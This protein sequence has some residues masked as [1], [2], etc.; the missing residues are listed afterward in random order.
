MPPKVTLQVTAGPI[1][2]RTYEF[3]SHDTFLFGRSPDCHAELAA[4]DTTASRHHFLLEVN[5]PQARLRDLGSL[6]GTTLNGVRHGGRGRQQSP[7][8]AARQEWPRLDLKDGDTIRVGHTV[9][10]VQIQG[11]VVPPHDTDP[12]AALEGLLGDPED[13]APGEL[14]GYRLERQLGRGGMGVVYLARRPHD[15]EPVALKVMLSQVL[16]DELARAAFHREVEVTRSLQHPNIVALLDHGSE[17]E[18]FYFAMEYCPGGSLDGLLRRRG[19]PLDLGLAGSIALQALEGLAFAHEWGFIHR[20]VK[21]ENILLGDAAGGGVKVTDFGLAKSFQQ[22]G[23]SGMTATGMVG[24][25]TYFMPREQLTNFRQTRPA[26]DVWSLAATLYYLL[27]L[28][29]ARDFELGQDPLAVILRGGVVPIRERAPGLPERV[30]AVVDRALADD[31]GE[32]Y[33][34]AAEF[35]TALAAV[36]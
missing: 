24:G 31:L 13:P 9:F 3:L 10:Q 28:Q 25:T 26:S 17:G 23:L 35:R 36:L 22:A 16:V 34:T 4:D 14:G 21:P 30:A 8:E 27:T 7:E 32:R 29:Y 1:A 20:D 12:L 11:G 5:P 33:A 2:G 15:G 18:R 6:N 19:G